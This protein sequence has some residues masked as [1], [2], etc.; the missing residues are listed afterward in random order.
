MDE[1]VFFDPPMRDPSRRRSPKSVQFGN[2]TTEYGIPGRE[3]SMIMSSPEGRRL[4]TLSTILKK[5]HSDS[6]KSLNKRE[7]FER[8]SR[9]RVYAKENLPEVVPIP[10]LGVVKARMIVRN[11]LL[12]VNNEVDGTM[13]SENETNA[14]VNELADSYI[15]AKLSKNIS[16]LAS[17]RN[18][19]RTLREG[20]PASEAA[21]FMLLGGSKRSY[22][23]SY[24][25]RKRSPKRK[26]RKI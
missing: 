20:S 2:F 4:K 18:A 17:F 21:N 15:T 22:K 3:D 25:R 8:R 5:E 1:Y 19:I 26:S 16:N 7:A 13:I 11:L 12:A 10:K 23:R 24:S 14:L 9:G 6:V